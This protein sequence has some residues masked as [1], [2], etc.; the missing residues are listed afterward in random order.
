MAHL[1]VLAFCRAREELLSRGD[2]HRFRPLLIPAEHVGEDHGVGVMVDGGHGGG[3]VVDSRK[4]CGSCPV[5]DCSEKEEYIR[6][7]RRLE[8]RM[9]AEAKLGTGRG[10]GSGLWQ[11]ARD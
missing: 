11:K 8:R 4:G 9:M 2:I 5:V 1:G 6:A 10:K 3:R 7:A